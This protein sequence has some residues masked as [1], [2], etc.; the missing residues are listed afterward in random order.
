MIKKALILIMDGLGDRAIDN[1]GNKT[2]LERA[3][4]PNFD[5]LVRKSECGLMYSLSRGRR[6]GSDTAHLSIFGYDINKYYTGRGPIEAAGVGIKLEKGDVALRGNFATV[7]SDLNIIDRRAGRINDVSLFASK[8]DGM[9]IDGIKFIVKPGSGYRAGVVLRGEGLSSNITDADSHKEGD[10]VLKVL[11][12]DNTKEAIF[13]AQVLNK[14]MM[15]SYEILDNLE[16]NKIRENNKELKAN[17]LLLRGAG[18]YPEIPSLTSKWGFN[19]ACCIAGGGLYKGIGSFLGMDVID[20]EGANAL[21]NTNIK[22]K[23][24]KAVECLNNYDFVFTHIKATDSLAED[25]KYNEKKLFI[26]RIDKYINI[27]NKVDDETLII[28]TSDHSTSSELKAHTADPV[29][30]LFY[31]KG[32]R[33]DSVSKFSERDFAKGSL[34]IINGIDIMP[35]ILNIMGKLPIIGC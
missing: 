28:I 25:G 9:E 18:N 2:P 19:K 7:D 5:K 16:E 34:G 12:L 3:N 6:P 11:P 30:I 4:T 27:L 17:F 31:Y 21:A 20:V 33:S 1:L 10:K 35:N 29:P 32:V 15:K 23:L 14:F 13:T 22:G 26:E 8:L 24:T